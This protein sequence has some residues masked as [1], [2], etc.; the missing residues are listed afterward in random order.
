PEDPVTYE[1]ARAV[2]TS[3]VIITAGVIVLILLGAL[4]VISLS[5]AVIRRALRPRGD[6]AVDTARRRTLLPLL[7]NL[8]QYVVVFIAVVM[9]LRQIGVD[10]TAIIA[11]AGIV[12]LAVG[13]GAQTLI[14]DLIAGFFLLSEGL[15]RVGDEIT[16]DGKTGIVDRISIRTTQVRAP[17]GVL[18]TVPNGMLQVFGKHA[19]GP[20]A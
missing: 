3:R 15:I 9:I 17:D 5:R 19:K 10:A 14:R 12:G 20:G 11:S 6:R 4:V 1:L 13:F 18:W 2:L 16:F 8:V 7:E